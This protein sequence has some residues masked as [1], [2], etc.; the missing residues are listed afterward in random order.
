M[1]IIRMA[2]IKK[3]R[4]ELSR[5]GRQGYTDEIR[6]I[7]GIKGAPKDAVEVF[8]LYLA[9]EAVRGRHEAIAACEALKKWNGG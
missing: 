9:L 6:A 4:E 3:M 1:Y 8:I 7:S 5:A 2:T